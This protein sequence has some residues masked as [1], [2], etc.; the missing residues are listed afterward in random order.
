MEM[1]IKRNN[2]SIQ[3]REGMNYV[4]GDI[5]DIVDDGRTTDKPWLTVIA[6]PG[7]SKEKVM[8]LRESVE[9]PVATT[10][11]VREEKY[12]KWK[13]KV[14]NEVIND[15]QETLIRDEYKNIVEISN[16]DG[17]VT[18]QADKMDLTK[19]RRFKIPN[20]VMDNLFTDGVNRVEITKEQFK[21]HI[22]KLTDRAHNDN[23]VENTTWGSSFTDNL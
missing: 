10:F 18:I 4:R 20:N 9:E 11:K 21:K 17:E 16:I 1:I 15:K 5:I 12:N 7:L 22:K 14:S 3:G 2:S 8:K 13:D 23:D 6:V 19:K